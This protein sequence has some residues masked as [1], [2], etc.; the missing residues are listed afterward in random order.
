MGLIV[1]DEVQ[2]LARHLGRLAEP[3]R[4]APQ[5]RQMTVSTLGDGFVNVRFAGSTVDVPAAFLSSYEPVA[6][7]VVWV[8]RNGPDLLVLGSLMPSNTNK[9]Q[10]VGQVVSTP[11]TTAS[12]SHTDLATVGPQVECVC[13]PS[14]TFLVAIDFWAW[15]TAAS[16]RC[17]AAFQIES[18]ATP[19][20]G[21]YTLGTSPQDLTAADLITP[22]AGST[23]V[24][25]AGKTRYIN[26]T[27]GA[28]YR[29][30]MKYKTGGATATFSSR[31][32]TVVPVV[33]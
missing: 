13:P 8:M 25:Q 5:L 28:E 12:T 24:T 32:I 22:G 31:V 17:Q 29:F 15:H 16:V 1:G 9:P 14:G 3:D 7:D 23:F 18:R 4:L 19:G 10:T 6:G 33:H 30:T 11:E 21:A 27:P 26:A 20:S 2:D